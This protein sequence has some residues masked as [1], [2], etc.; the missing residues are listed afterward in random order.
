MLANDNIITSFESDVEK[1]GICGLN[2]VAICL[3]IIAAWKL[4]HFQIQYRV[5]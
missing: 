1:F 2:Q 3:L 4:G 5:R